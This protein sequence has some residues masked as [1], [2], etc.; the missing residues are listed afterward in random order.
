MTQHE[1][2][3]VGHKRSGGQETIY[4]GF[5]WGTVSDTMPNN[6][7]PDPVYG[8]ADLYEDGR[9]IETSETSLLGSAKTGSSLL[10]WLI[11]VALIV[12]IVLAFLH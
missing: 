9:L 12:L 6:G 8:R 7:D 4:T 1:Y 10:S 3:I 11:L 2:R 5:D